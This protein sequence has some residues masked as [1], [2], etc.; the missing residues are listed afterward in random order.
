MVSA[1]G[2]CK[3][4]SAVLLSRTVWRKEIMRHIDICLICFAFYKT[5]NLSVCVKP[6]QDNRPENVRIMI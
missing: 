4:S 3:Y 5:R 1:E 2:V 6:Y